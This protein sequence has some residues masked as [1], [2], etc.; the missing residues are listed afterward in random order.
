MGRRMYGSVGMETEMETI[1]AI[2]IA[3]TSVGIQGLCIFRERSNNTTPRNKF[4]IW[5][6]GILI[7]TVVFQI[8]VLPKTYN[9]NSHLSMLLAFAIMIFFYCLFSLQMVRRARDAGMGKAI[10]YLWLIPVV[11]NLCALFLIFKSTVSKG[12]V[13]GGR[14]AGM[15]DEHLNQYGTGLKQEQTFMTETNENKNVSAI[16]RKTG[17]AMM[18]L[19]GIAL[20]AVFLTV[21]ISGGWSNTPDLIR[22]FGEFV[23]SFSDIPILGNFV[24]IIW[25]LVFVGPGLCVQFLGNLLEKN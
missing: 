6:M 20:A 4:V 16:L 3:L 9:S 12:I 17:G 11:G 14:E 7:G 8:I 2:A 25:V 24:L 1:M 23:R 21:L 22:T 18:L 19:G 10:A 5:T 15:V 13:G